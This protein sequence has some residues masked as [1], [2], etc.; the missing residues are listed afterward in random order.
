MSCCVAREQL[1]LRCF[2]ESGQEGN[3]AL[4]GRVSLGQPET[5]TG[6]RLFHPFYK[7]LS[8]GVELRARRPFSCLDKSK[9]EPERERER[10]REQAN[11]A[12]ETREDDLTER[13]AFSLPSCWNSILNKARWRG[14]VQA[15][16]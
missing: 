4:S 6:E 8:A 1:S 10:E 11:V 2:L 16:K 7:T 12:G 3:N 5:R 9:K 15:H 13:A 14:G